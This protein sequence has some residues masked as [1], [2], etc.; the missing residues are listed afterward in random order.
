MTPD[1]S[2]D[3]SQ[4]AFTGNTDGKVGIFVMDADGRNVHPVT[5]LR[6][7]EGADSPS[8]SP[9]G[10]ALAYSAHGDIYVQEADRSETTNLTN[11]R[12]LFEAGPEWSPDGDQIA[13]LRGPCSAPCRPTRTADVFLMDAQGSNIRRLTETADGGYSPTSI[14]NPSWL[15]TAGPDS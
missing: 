12:D 3:G 10:R 11:T 9:D 8:W 5:P 1:Y 4:I 13:F 7:D 6:G 2:P 14:E 15:F